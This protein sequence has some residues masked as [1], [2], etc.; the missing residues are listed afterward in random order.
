MNVEP[1]REELLLLPAE[2]A[3]LAKK[4]KR[5]IDSLA[6]E[7]K[8]KSIGGRTGTRRIPVSELVHFGWTYEMLE[9]VYE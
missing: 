3:F 8:I 7:G 4:S 2:F 5:R 6:Q 9:R 1:E